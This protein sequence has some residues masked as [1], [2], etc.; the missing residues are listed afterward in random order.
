LDELKKEVKEEDQQVEADKND[1]PENEETPRVRKPTGAVSLDV[2]KL[3]WAQ[4]LKAVKPHNHSLEA[5]LKATQPMKVQADNLVIEVFYM[6]HKEQLEQERHRKTIEQIVESVLG[7]RLK[8]QFVLGKKAVPTAEIDE[9]IANV[10]G[11]VSDEELAEAAEE[12]F[13]N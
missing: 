7:C 8:L 6:F 12:I 3:N 2:V 13:G 4:V 1:L 9:R 11:N 10:T 5:L